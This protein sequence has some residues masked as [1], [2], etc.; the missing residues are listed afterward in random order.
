MAQLVVLIA[1]LLLIA[2]SQASDVAEA[3]QGFLSQYVAAPMQRTPTSIKGDQFASSGQ[4]FAKQEFRKQ[5]EKSAQ[6]LVANDGNTPMTLSAVGVGLLALMTMLGVQIRRVLRPATTLASSGLADNI[7][8][9][10]SQG[11]TT[12]SA[13]KWDPLNLLPSDPIDGQR[14]AVFAV[15]P[16]IKLAGIG[17][18]LI[19]P[20]FTL[21]NKL[22][23]AL[24]GLIGGVDA[25]DVKN[26][27]AE[28]IKAPVVI[29]TY[30]LSPFSTSAVSLLEDKG[31]K[32]EVKQLGLEWFLLGPRASVKRSELQAMTGQSSLP[33]VF[34]GGKH[35]GG[36]AT[37]PGIASLDESGELDGLLK[38]AGGS[39][40]NSGGGGFEFPKLF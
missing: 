9:L 4:T 26:E 33:H 28:E 14:P 19:G 30:G 38:S 29:Y 21:E 8:E 17:M 7:M 16:A 10:Q 1:G 40:S 13:I 32:F 24:L 31:A 22:Q 39:S 5:E 23:A 3:D 6:K 15:N 20:V 25:D 36:L 12:K 11:S 27:I 2:E 34:I 35:V 18:S 37:G